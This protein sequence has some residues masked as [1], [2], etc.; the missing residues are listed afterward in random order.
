VNWAV[1]FRHLL[2]AEYILAGAKFGTSSDKNERYK[3][4]LHSWGSKHV[5][6]SSPVYGSVWSHRILTAMASHSLRRRFV[7]LA[8]LSAV[9]QAKTVVESD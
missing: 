8:F 9:C 2:S 6:R 7:A 3:P 4:P 5:S 1:I